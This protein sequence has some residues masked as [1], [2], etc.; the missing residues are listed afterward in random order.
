M[1]LEDPSDVALAQVPARILTVLDQTHTSMSIR[2]IARTSGTSLAR[3]QYWLNHWAERGVVDQQVAGRAVM[4]SLNRQ[5][6]MTESL[7]TLARANL[8][9]RDR[10]AD[11]VRAWGLVPVSVTAFGSFA[12]GDGGTESDIDLLVIHVNDASS[13]RWQDQL[14]EAAERLQRILGN[15]VQWV[16][17][18]RDRW[19][20]MRATPEPLVAEVERDAVHIF[21]EHLTLITP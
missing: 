19:L 5:H 12:R 15:P 20:E 6:L 13:E 21:G 18:H 16:D 8:A 9:M 4:C 14:T 3:A 1:N 10:I 11:E 17:F 7:V 2:Q